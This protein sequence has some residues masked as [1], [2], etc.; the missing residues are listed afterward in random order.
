MYQYYGIL[1][2]YVTDNVRK[3][4]SFVPPQSNMR[5]MLMCLSY[6]QTKTK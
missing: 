3:A 2:L 1:K 5:Y 4:K 6:T